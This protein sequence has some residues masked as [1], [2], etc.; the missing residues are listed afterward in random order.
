MRDEGLRGLMTVTA[1]LPAASLGFPPVREDPRSLLIR[2][3]SSIKRAFR[4]TYHQEKSISPHALHTHLTMSNYSGHNRVSTELACHFENHPDSRFGGPGSHVPPL[5]D[6]SS[7]IRENYSSK[8]GKRSL[9]WPASS[10]DKPSA[11]S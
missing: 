10:L 2:S 4:L 3:S 9:T 11:T 8:S 7:R 1:F 5:P 6:R